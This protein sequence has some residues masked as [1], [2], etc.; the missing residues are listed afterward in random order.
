M[1]QQTKKSPRH[2]RE[3]RWP[4]IK[5]DLRG[6]SRQGAAFLLGATFARAAVIRGMQ[7]FGVAYVA[8]AG[9]PLA[10]A[11]GGFAASLTDGG[12]VYGAASVVILAC[13]MVLEG[14][15]LSRRQGFF[16]GCAAL[17][18]LFTKGVVAAAQ[19][20]RAMVLLLCE[21]ALCLGF[22]FMLREAR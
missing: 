15:A 9:H 4:D 14:T 16:P 18:L 20:M 13:R 8:A 10:A 17:A 7:P 5:L 3:R 6:I 11:V 2:V 21:C 22:A 19:G 12:L 1:A